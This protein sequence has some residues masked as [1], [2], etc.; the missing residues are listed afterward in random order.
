MTFDPSLDNSAARLAAMARAAGAGPDLTQGGGGNVSLKIGPERMLIKASGSRLAEMTG[1]SGYAL[2]NHGNIKRQL[3]GCRMDDGELLEYLCAQSLPVKGSSAAKPSVET[4]FH[5]L[6]N[7]AVVHIHS[8]CANVLNMTAEGRAAAARLFPGAAW[9]D[10]VPPGARLCCAVDGPG[11]ATGTQ[12]LF[13]AN[14][15]LVVSAPGSEAAL[16]RA[17]RVNA[18][19]RSAL[20]LPLYPSAD[21]PA[22]GL[23]AHNKARLE[24][25]GKAFMLDNV[26]SPDQALY[27]GPA[28]LD[29]SGKDMAAV[30]EVLTA[31]FYILDCADTLGWTPRFLTKGDRD[32][33]EGMKGGRYRRGR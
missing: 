31:I 22:A 2:V 29:G 21:Y 28:E 7:T 10:Y 4:G 1:I 33:L 26:L 18:E 19:I 13:L 24:R 25:R 17:L 11:R 12:V 14:H 16:E 32:Y 30:N 15:G 3:A 8:A 6:L 5:A 9:I 20:R 27:C 23:S